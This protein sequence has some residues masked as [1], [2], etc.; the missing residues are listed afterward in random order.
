MLTVQ[1]HF[2]P[3]ILK[4]LFGGRSGLTETHAHFLLVQIIVNQS[5]YLSINYKRFCFVVLVLCLR[6]LLRCCYN[7]SLNFELPQTTRQR[8][9][10]PM[11]TCAWRRRQTNRQ[12]RSGSGDCMTASVGS[13]FVP[14]RE[15]TPNSENSGPVQISAQL[16]K[17]ARR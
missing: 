3:P 1:I 13:S 12:A 7:C 6:C 14:L 5:Q 4:S 16:L 17:M 8:H 15:G 2:W 9:I 11:H 10:T